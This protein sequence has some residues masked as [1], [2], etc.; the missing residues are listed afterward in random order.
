MQKSKIE[1]L[2]LIRAI[3][4]IGV[5]LTHAKF[6][7]WSGG[8]AYLAKYPTATWHPTDYPLFFTDLISSLGEQR[9]Y[10]FFILSGFFIQ[11]SVRHG[12]SLPAFLR[13]RLLRIYPAYVVS[14]LLAGL[15]L[16]VAVK[17]ISPAIYTEHLR[18]LNS[19]LVSSY[20]GLTVSSLLH[21][22]FFTNDG[23]YFGL[24]IQYWSLKHEMLFYALFP[25]YVL[26]SFRGQLGLLGLG[27]GLAAFTTNS[28]V[29]CQL[30]FLI[31]MLFYQLFERGIQLPGTW[32]A[33]AYC[34]AFGSLY[35]SIYLLNKLQYKYTSSLLTVVL[36]FLA[37]EFLLT[38]PVRVP[39][40]LTW[41]STISYSVYLN[42]FW[43]LLLYY[44]VLSRLSGEL[45]FYSRWPY[46]TGAIVAVLCSLPGYYLLEKPIVAYLRRS[47]R[48]GQAPTITHEN[49]TG[50]P[51]LQLLQSAAQIVRVA[52]A[53]KA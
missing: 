19:R 25:F 10:L 49:T 30:F 41:L 27:L 6:V 32:P 4:M 11:Y 2:H 28:L 47:G 8:E 16:Y 33:W 37:L 45:V 39:R 15:A 21:T 29:F 40:F 12:F 35:L 31:G 52:V 1:Q 7:L 36:A 24:T 48:Q 26:C 38:R 42:H 46:Y 17:V 43:G 20:Q 34:T 18:E 3:A 14:A 22:L 51:K 53:E 13:K 9:V 44:A 5:V 50:L 23:E